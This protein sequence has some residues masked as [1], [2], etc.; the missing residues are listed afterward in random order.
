M[1]DTKKRLIKFF[2][3]HKEKEF[4]MEYYGTGFAIKGIKNTEFYEDKN[5]LIVCLNNKIEDEIEPIEKIQIDFNDFKKP[6]L[7]EIIDTIDKEKKNPPFQWICD[8]III[9]TVKKHGNDY[10]C[11]CLLHLYLSDIQASLNLLSELFNRN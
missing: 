7:K 11:I 5:I 10:D 4:L 6:N 9:K 3:E 1:V 8:D 2:E